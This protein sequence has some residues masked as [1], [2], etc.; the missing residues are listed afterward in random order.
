M[1]A[2]EWAA[3]QAER[4][5]SPL[6]IVSAPAVLP[7]VHALPAFPPAL[8]VPGVGGGILRAAPRGED[9]AEAAS[10]LAGMLAGWRDKYPAVRVR[11]DVVHGHPARVLASYSARADLVVLGRHGGP[12]PGSAGIGSV[13][14]AVP[15]LGCD[16]RRGQRPDARR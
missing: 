13:Q 5:G 1:R 2:V 7:R 15:D 11:H 12:A 3:R 14:H 16:R 4:H 8:H 6:R 9:L 10:Q